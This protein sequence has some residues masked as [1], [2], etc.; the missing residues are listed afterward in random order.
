MRRLSRTVTRLAVAGAVAG[1]ALGPAAALAASGDLDASTHS[2]GFDH[3]LSDTSGGPDAVV[4]GSVPFAAGHLDPP[5]IGDG[6]VRFDGRPTDYLSIAHPVLDY[7][8][9][10]FT[11][12]LW[13]STTARKTETI[14]D[15]GGTCGG[16]GRGF[17]LIMSATGHLSV[18]VGQSGEDDGSH[19]ATPG[20]DA[21][22]QSAAV[23]AFLHALAAEDPGGGGD[24]PH[25]PT[26]G[27]PRA[28]D[29]H[30]HE[31]TLVRTG[32]TIVVRL[33]TTIEQTLTLTANPDFTGDVG[34][35]VGRGWCEGDHAFQGELDD[36]SA[37]PA[38][39][40]ALPEAPV[41]AILPVSAAMIGAVVVARRRRRRR[42]AHARRR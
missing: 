13:L 40:T 39:P 30:W 5:E 31:A 37:T 1:I 7:G 21:K 6:A 29:G 22:T 17:A 16:G 3:N 24:H 2:Y 32:P 26:P 23:A 18:R 8:T 9:A 34:V 27:T 28:N 4:H 15:A 38:P 12:D 41:A 10:D 25:D 36:L 33:D 14:L 35:R 20:D 19:T 42:P 11:I